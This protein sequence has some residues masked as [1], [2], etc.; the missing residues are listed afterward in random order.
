MGYEA[1][2]RLI[3]LIASAV[4]LV[5]ALPLWILVAAAIKLDSPGPVLF[6]QLRVGRGGSEF[7]MVKFRTMEH[8]ADE[9]FLT[10]HLSHLSELGED[11]GGESAQ[12]R[13]EDDPRVT[14]VGRR[15]RR[16]S[17]DELPNLWNVFVGPMSLVGPRPLVPAEVE[18]IGERARPRLAVKPGITGL[19]QIAGRTYLTIDERTRFDLEYV[20][21]RSLR[22][23]FKIMAETMRTVFR[24]PGS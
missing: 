3:D 4:A 16:W 24:H 5:L 17:L 6:S 9:S 21:Q 13:L 23:D 22:L 18:I 11:A 20:E 12:L 1:T 8:G 7:V 19:A 15:L 2:K 10:E 14:R